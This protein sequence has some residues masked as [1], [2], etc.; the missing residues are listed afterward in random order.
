MKKKLLIAVSMLCVLCCIIAAIPMQ[1]D[2][3]DASFRVGY[4]RVDINP[5]VVDGDFSSGI[6]A[7]PL[8]G[9]GDVWN[10]LSRSTLMDDNGDG[11]VDAEDGLKATCIAVSDKDGTTV[12]LITVDVIG[13]SFLGK[14]TTEILA[15]VEA[16]I[17]AG[18]LT[19]V[20]LA[21]ENIYAASTHTHN[22]PDTA[23]Y[24]SGGKT[25]TNKDGV[26]LSVVNQN[27]GMWIDRTVVDIGDAAIAAL[28]DRAEAT[29]SRDQLSVS[30]V[31]SPVVKGK[32]MT[33]TRHYV[34]TDETGETFVA[35]DNFNGTSG[36]ITGRGDDPKQVTEADDTIYLLNFKF[37]DTT[38]L[39]VVLTSWRGHPSLHNTDTYQNSSRLAVSSDYV[40]AFRH[41]L[42]FGVDVTINTTNGIGN[43]TSWDLGTQQKYRVAFFNSTG[44]NTNP[45]GYELKRDETGKV[46]T[47]GTNNTPL[48]GYTWIDQ[49]AT[50]AEIKGRGC[51]FGV[52][53]AT[54]ANECLTDGKNETVARP[55]E[56]VSA[57]KTFKAD[58]KTVG[59]S[60]LAHDAGKAYNAAVPLYDAAY[61][62]YQTARTKYLAY[63]EAQKKVDNAGI[64][65]ILYV[66]ARD[67][68]KAAYEEAM[69]A[70]SVALAPFVEFM[71]ANTTDAPTVSYAGTSY[72]AH[73]DKPQMLTP[74]HY[75]SA[76]G[77][78]YVIG[79][80]FHANY[81]I[82]DWN[83][84]LGIPYTTGINVTVNAFMLGQ[85]VAF[86]TIPGEPF[87]YYYKELGVYTPEN[88]LW[89]DLIGENYGKPYIL[90]YANGWQR[91]FPNYEAYLYNEG[92]IN[93]TLGSYEAHNADFEV[94]TG[95]RTVKALDS[96]LAGL[97][98]GQRQAACHHCGE[99]V[100]WQPYLGQ[101]TLDT[102]HYY[103]CSDFEL[104]AQ[105][106]FAENC[107][108]CFDL[109]G[110]TLT[111][112]GRAFYL[113]DNKNETLNIMDT[114]QTQTGAAE[115]CA[116]EMGAAVGY[117]GGTVYAGFGSTLNLYSGTLRTC[118]RKNFSCQTGSVIR[119]RSVFNMYGGRVEGGLVSSFAG[120]YIA[121]GKPADAK[122][123][124]QAGAIYVDGSFNLY[125]GI[126]TGGQLQL[127][128][129][130]VFG[131]D[132]VGYG[133]RQTTELMEA[134]DS[135]VYVE[136]NAS[137][138][139]AGSGSVRNLYLAGGTAAKLTVKGNYTG[140]V[141]I[142]YPEETSLDVMQR[143]AVAEKSDEGRPADVSCATV[144]FA[145]VQGLTA[146]VMDDA[147]LISEQPESYIYC[148]GCEEYARWT[149][150]ADAQLD[151]ATNTKGMKPGH[152][153]LKEYVNTTQKQLNPDGKN[154]GT[155]CFDL[156]GYE[157]HGTTRAFYVYD[158]A[159]LNLQDSCG[160]GFV[161]GDKGANNYGGS[162]YCQGT[163]AVVNVYGIT[164]KAT[165]VTN[166]RGSAI[167]LVNGTVN[168][169]D[170]EVIG[171]HSKDYGGTV[172][173]AGNGKLH[174]SGGTVAAGTTDGK[175]SCV[176]VDINGKVCLSGNA[177]VDEIYVYGE[178]ASAVT[179]DA[180]L[181]AFTGKTALRFD[182]A[183]TEAN[184]DVGDLLGDKGMEN[185]DMIAAD[186]ELAVVAD[187]ADLKTADMA[188]Q[189]IVG[190]K[191]QQ[192]ANLEKALVAYEGNGF[193]R[194]NGQVAYDIVVTKNT[195]LDLNGFSIAGSIT[196]EEGVTLYCMDSA[197]DDYRIFDE[198][199]GILSGSIA[200]NVLPVPA[201][202]VSACESEE[203]PT[204]AGYI[205]VDRK[206]GLSFHRVK[207]QIHSVAMRPGCVGLYYQCDFKADEM[208]AEEIYGFGVALSVFD[209]PNADNLQTDCEYTCYESFEGGPTGN[210][211][212]NTGTLLQNIMR[213]ANT[214][215]VNAANAGVPIYGRAYI[216][217][218]SGYVFGQPVSCSLQSVMEGIDEIWST[219]SEKQR[220]SAQQLYRSYENIMSAWELPNIK[221]YS[222]N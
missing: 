104:A 38:K 9:S 100:T 142:G 208:A 185:A 80:K 88:N 161:Q 222:G 101:A 77:E 153:I 85:D 76:E 7:L 35:G 220:L 141:E 47:Y 120:Q 33:M 71:Q 147:V 205:S 170:A 73:P 178:A 12:L 66:S 215:A 57:T 98:L 183:V 28:K 48:V 2:A 102:G 168:L 26:D 64:A 189:I 24:A 166:L 52:V 74:F 149:P 4:S 109:N 207:L 199:Y 167:F 36:K 1:G 94:G 190:D 171:N 25:G 20:K 211:G 51:S 187:G 19:D 108:V 209:I 117:G 32:T 129:G 45:R 63:V 29:L 11:V 70:H 191:V 79:S 140:T 127:I 122:R 116:A 86:V 134:P 145:G 91:Y 172:F 181:E 105:I 179:V 40:N 95:E 56:I 175:G 89:N 106:R 110:Y 49:S 18:N 148:H 135:C 103:L 138:L 146:A 198:P 204:R 130:E 3:A 82:G 180:T 221:H 83:A 217:T 124:G 87:D 13:M 115:G 60:Q 30:D 62:T 46:I 133:Y 27:L 37:A 68:A 143:I 155:F 54:L 152:Y 188:V 150:I 39:P 184:V 125:G 114:S 159:T 156:N 154:P 75:K 41:A 31:T 107:G 84:K 14:I 121:K 203:D 43:V 93:K 55:G 8:A 5:Y 144:S 113:D 173:C 214:A 22:A 132:E 119:A 139:L 192:F 81:V 196:V 50:S 158:N 218:E 137:V 65:G 16:E 160:G 195:Y 10:R 53:L 216:V 96:L 212:Q 210:A 163:N 206:A 118:E 69:A 165:P 67:K 112:V 92:S 123:V 174:V 99:I 194:L 182:K 6:M 169:Y 72:A 177:V 197:T 97:S 111:G 201:D 164:V 131:S 59:C 15:R 162:M 176:F 58:R 21:K 34:T 23:S 151:L 157:F 17:A 186:A 44:G 61:A 200:G 193:I 202:T 126:V 136:K 42:E 78:T 219:L 213:P 128:T 90:G